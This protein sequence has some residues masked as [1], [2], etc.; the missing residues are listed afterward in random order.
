VDEIAL[1]G[2]GEDSNSGLFAIRINEKSRHISGGD[3]W[4]N[5]KNAGFGY[6]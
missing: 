3:L 6:S 2:S 1:C 4:F 5:L